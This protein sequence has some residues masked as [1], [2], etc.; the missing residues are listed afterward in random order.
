MPSASCPSGRST[1]GVRT[2]ARA[3]DPVPVPVPR[4][5]NQLIS[6]VLCR[7]DSAAVR[8]GAAAGRAPTR[9]PVVIVINEDGSLRTLGAA[10]RAFAPVGEPLRKNAMTDFDFLKFTQAFGRVITAFR[11][12]LT[13]SEREELTRTY[14]KI[15]D[16]HAIDDVIAAGKRCIEKMRT[17]PKAADWLAELAQT[18]TATC[19]PDRRTMRVDEADEL[20]RAT[21]LRYDDQPCLCAACCRAGV[22]DRSLRFVPSE[23]S[24]DEL[25]RAFNPRTSRVEVV[26]HWAHGEELARWYLARETFY[27]LAR[28]APRPLFDA[29]AVLVG[30]N[31]REREVGEEG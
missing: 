4:R 13:G 7:Q 16:A 18:Q 17:F 21:A 10:R 28:R 24:P 9:T 2:L 6:K 5:K 29:V 14:F 15:L 8:G 22:D 1:D 23:F 3:R 26:G 25:E 20:A 31:G 12:K 30:D 11:I 27:G 19:P